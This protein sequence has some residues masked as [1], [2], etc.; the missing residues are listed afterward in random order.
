MAK[1]CGAILFVLTVAVLFLAYL[2]LSRTEPTAADGASNALQAWDLLHGNLLLRG[3][4]LTDVSFYTTELPEYM[5]VE[6]IRGLNADVL[7]VAAALTYALIVPLAAVLAKGRATGHEA[8]VRMLIAGGILIAP[9]PGPGVFIVLFQPDH[10]GT[11]VPTLLTWLI[12]D[13]APQRWYTPVLIGILLTWIGIA[14]KIVLLIGVLPLV[15][16]CAIRVLSG[17]LRTKPWRDLPWRAWPALSLRSAWF[18][19]S[20]AIAAVLSYPFSEM[21]V[22]LIHAAGGYTILPVDTGVASAGVLPAHFRLTGGGVL[23]LFG[24]S[25]LYRPHGWNLAF[26]ILHLAGVALAIWA[27]SLAFRRYFRDGDLIA[28][29][30]ALG[31]VVNIGAYLLNSRP[32]TYFSA[33][34]IAGVLPAGAVLAG[35]MLGPRLASR[36]GSATDRAESAPGPAARRF[37]RALT[38]ALSIVLAGYLAALGYAATRPPQPGVGQDLSGWLSHHGLTYGLA[39]YGL[40]SPTTL[41]ADNSLAV[42]PVITETA[43][44]AP[45][46]H[47]FDVNWYDPRAHHANFVVLLNT[48]G[49]LD[50]MTIGQIT[51][52]FGPP[53]HV[54]HYKNYEILTWRKN[55]LA[56]LGAPSPDL[57]H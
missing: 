45:G 3:W 25:F 30:L 28:Q 53:T 42:R 10:F 15:V 44:L 41:A 13:R 56:D 24:A 6:V 52:G 27:L 19:I 14:D 50:P 48:P 36:S 32:A 35:R 31:I 11:Q 26:A 4:T 12:L 34:E 2:R 1:L 37:Y 5:I 18:E 49:P 43:R 7:H 46:P 17:W 57:D 22:R 8:I 33:R 54:Y 9:E 51:A 29:V 23:G 40:A 38:A 20:L 55:L 16:A 39:V 47:E 21:V